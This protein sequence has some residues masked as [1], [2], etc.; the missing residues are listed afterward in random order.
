MYVYMCQRGERIYTN[1]KQSKQKAKRS[2]LSIVKERWIFLML[3]S[4]LL[5][6]TSTT[7]IIQ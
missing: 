5:K 1:Q 7:L 3:D 6:K 2:L 4:I